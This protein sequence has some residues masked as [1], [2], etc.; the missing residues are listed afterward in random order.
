[1]Q[2]VSGKEEKTEIA[3]DTPLS[4]LHTETEVLQE[5]ISDSEKREELDGIADRLC[6]DIVD[7][8]KIM[9]NFEKLQIISNEEKQTLEKLFARANGFVLGIDYRR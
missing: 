4:E 3:K 9:R 7:M 8:E 1:V 6:N 5:S 2:K